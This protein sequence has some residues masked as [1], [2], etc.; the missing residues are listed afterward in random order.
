MPAAS[1]LVIQ[2]GL[3]TPVARTFVLL[4]PSAS[5]GSAA[6]WQYKAGANSSVFPTIMSSARKNQK[7]DA[8]KL[9]LTV[10]VPYGITD[11]NTNV[12][13]PGSAA[14]LNADI[15]IPDDFPEAAKSDAVAFMTN[16]F[17]QS[18]VKAMIRDAVSAT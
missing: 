17:Q 12:T 9:S 10:K 18:L 11:S 3:A 2:D 6:V 16:L 8:R 5:D 15:T 7:R 14:V 13:K 4:T 1:D